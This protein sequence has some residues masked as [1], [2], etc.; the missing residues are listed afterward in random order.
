MKLD[1]QALLASLCLLAAVVASILPGRRAANA[2][3]TEAL[4]AE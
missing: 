4:A 1:R 2:T 3:P